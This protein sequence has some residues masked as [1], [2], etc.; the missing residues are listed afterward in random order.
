MDDS[1]LD[2]MLRDAAQDHPE[3]ASHETAVTAVRSFWYS[4]RWPLAFG[5]AIASTVAAVAALIALGSSRDELGVVVQALT[6]VASPMLA[7][8]ALGVAYGSSLTS[9][10]FRWA[11]SLL[12][13]AGVGAAGVAHMVWYRRVDGDAGDGGGLLWLMLIAAAS[14]LLAVVTA[15]ILAPALRRSGIRRFVS[16]GLA[17]VA[18][19]CGAAFLIGLLALPFGAVVLSLL[20]FITT[21]LMYRT[22]RRRRK[23]LVLTHDGAD[24]AE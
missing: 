9:L 13:A 20:T 24:R 16:V 22:D 7:A 3:R 14:S 4:V 8:L 18:G 6:F 19:L 15:I 10:R 2:G 11:P 23:R 17:L 5:L 12:A 21:M 1:A